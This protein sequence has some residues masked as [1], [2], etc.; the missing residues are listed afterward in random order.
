MKLKKWIMFNDLH[1]P[2]QD[3]KCVQAMMTLA[4]EIK[5]DGFAIL[6]DMLDFYQASRFLKSTKR[7]ETMRQDIREG[8]MFLRRLRK[9]HPK[10]DIW[11]LE[12]NHEVR[13][14]D[15]IMKNANALEGFDELLIPNLLKLKELNVRY[16]CMPDEEYAD[17]RDTPHIGD[18]YLY[19]G[20]VVRQHSGYSAKAMFEKYGVSLIHGHTHRDGKHGRRTE[21]G[22]FVA[23]EN[24][25]MCKLNPRYLKF[26]NWVQ[27]FSVVLFEGNHPHITPIH[28]NKGKFAFGVKVYK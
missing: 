24:Y 18:L 28:V 27:G 22:L 23:H 15:Y 1:R 19:H 10:A 13:L 5:P 2:F 16:F 6:G 14:G 21:R 9:Q 8:E 7:Q 26:A 11:Y 20:D 25:C 3:D 17:T 4:K 12:G